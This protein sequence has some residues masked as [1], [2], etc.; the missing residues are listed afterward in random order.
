[1]KNTPNGYKFRTRGDDVLVFHNGRL[2]TTLRAEDATA[3]LADVQAGDEQA[4]MA[5]AAESGAPRGQQRI[6]NIHPRNAF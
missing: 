3:F 2:A 4:V 1:M 6:S 5:R